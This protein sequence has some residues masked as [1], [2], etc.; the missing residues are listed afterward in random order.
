MLGR[1][2]LN[3]HQRHEESPVRRHER[4]GD[5]EVCCSKYRQARARKVPVAYVVQDTQALDHLATSPRVSS[6]PRARTT[7]A[8]TICMSQPASNRNRRAPK[9]CLRYCDPGS[10]SALRNETECPKTCPHI[11]AASFRPGAL[12]A[13]ASRSTALIHAPYASSRASTDTAVGNEGS[14]E[15]GGRGP[16]GKCAL[17]RARDGFRFVARQFSTALWFL[18]TK[19]IRTELSRRLTAG[20]QSVEFTPSERHTSGSPTGSAS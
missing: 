15:G 16:D 9:P 10:P 7:S 17:G 12:N 11:A 18:K 1:A 5:A 13:S 2:T 19:G 8:H 3:E 4:H 14:S 20:P 6:A